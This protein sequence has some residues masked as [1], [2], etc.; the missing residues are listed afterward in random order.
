MS[1]VEFNQ[2]LWRSRRGILELDLLLVPF[3]QTRFS[4]LS[5]ELQRTY[6]ALLDNEDPVLLAWLKSEVEC[7]AHFKGIVR[8]IVSYSASADKNS[9]ST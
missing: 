5:K 8:L 7:P 9:D 2:V 6:I 1:R 4:K 3:A